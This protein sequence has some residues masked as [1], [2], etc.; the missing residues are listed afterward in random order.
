MG[1]FVLVLDV[2]A[3]GFESLVVGVSRLVVLSSAFVVGRGKVGRG[4]LHEHKEED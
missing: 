4:G 2:V 3:V 1:E